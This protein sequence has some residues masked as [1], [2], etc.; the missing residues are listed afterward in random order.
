MDNYENTAVAAAELTPEEEAR[1]EAFKGLITDMF[2]MP[3]MRS[4]A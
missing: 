1:R 4:A 2:G 3:V